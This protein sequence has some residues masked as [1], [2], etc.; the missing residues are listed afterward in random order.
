MVALREIL[1][2]PFVLRAETTEAPDG[3]WKRVVSYPEVGCQV[4]GPDLMTALREVEVQRV[5]ALVSAVELGASV[6]P[7]REAVPDA[8]V[9]DLLH[10]A[11]LSEWVDRLDEQFP[12]GEPASD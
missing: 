4:E 3:S 7:L 10:R 1:S 2:A 8:G 11:G 5:R 6:T 12:W 9:A